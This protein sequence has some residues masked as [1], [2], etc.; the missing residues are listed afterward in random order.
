MK[1]LIIWALA[2]LL[3][4]LCSCEN[5]NQKN[6]SDNVPTESVIV[7]NGE[8]LPVAQINEQIQRVFND[9]LYYGEYEWGQQQ[10]GINITYDL[11]L[12]H[13]PSQPYYGE[14]ADMLYLQTVD[15]LH[16]STTSD[17]PL[18]Y[19]FGIMLTPRGLQSEFCYV[20][21]VEDGASHYLNQQLPAPIGRYTMSI[22]QIKEP[23]PYEHSDQWRVQAEKAIMAFMD[24]N[25]LYAIPEYN[26]KQGNYAVYV[27]DFSNSDQ[28]A[29]I[30][31]VHEDG[32]V[33]TGEYLSVNSIYDNEA[34]NLNRISPVEEPE[35][36]SF[37]EYLKKLEKHSALVMEYRVE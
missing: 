30:V 25:N 23:T 8:N 9:S 24:Q 7:S 11:Y 20:G 4:F 10:N 21:P 18:Y 5:G 26:L 37:S 32:S 35:D 13:N 28:T 31:F 2:F 29:E 14:N 33:Y 19:A 27:E 22:E 6:A 16:P 34:A 12:I 3:L 15:L 1:R 36:Q 17:C